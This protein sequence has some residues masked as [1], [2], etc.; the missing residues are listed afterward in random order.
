MRKYI[1]ENIISF[2]IG[3]LLAIPL[4]IATIDARQNDSTTYAEIEPEVEIESIVYR[5]SKT[6]LGSYKVTAYCACSKCC[7]EWADGITYTGTVATEG[8]TVAVDPEIIP[9]GSTIE[10]N[11]V[12]YIA[13]DI[14]G[15]VKGNHVDIFFNNHSDA[16]NWG[17]QYHNI[18]LIEEVTNE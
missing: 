8:R 14:G 10:I 16:V 13:E 11:G 6:A 9:L 4:C 3:I 1:N 15:A 5:P 12:K 7:D 18:Y 17:K 2:L